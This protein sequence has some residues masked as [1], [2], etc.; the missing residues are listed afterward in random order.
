LEYVRCNLC[1]SNEYEVL[2]ENPGVEVMTSRGSLNMNVVN[3]AC[4]NCGLLCLIPR[5]DEQETSA[6]YVCQFRLAMT[7][8]EDE[9]EVKGGTVRIEQADRI[10][11][12]LAGR[13]PGRVLDVGCFEG[14]FLHIM[15]RRGWEAHGVEP[16]KKSVQVARRK[17]KLDVHGGMYEQSDF[18]KHS[19]DL[20]TMRHVLEHARNPSD[21]LMLANYHLRTGGTLFLEIPNVYRPFGG[22]FDDFFS[23]Q[24][25]YNFSPVTL[26]MVLQKAGFALTGIETDLP[27]FAFRVLAEKKKDHGWKPLPFI[28]NNDFDTVRRIVDSYRTGPD[29]TELRQ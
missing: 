24:H 15:A 8:G 6:C 16:C 18:E 28:I 23:F 11:E 14:Y 20:V 7:G 5:M 22:K 21:M 12:H 4:T 29:R 17:Y 9:D 10:S 26:N 25:F 27:Y 2:H 13:P 1:G 19:F 3:V